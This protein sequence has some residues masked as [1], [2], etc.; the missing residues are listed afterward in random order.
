MICENP[1]RI[2]NPYTGQWLYTQ[3]RKCDGCVALQ[4]VSKTM[5]LTN[6][7]N[8]FKNVTFVTL[9]YDNKHLPI[10]LPYTSG[11][12]RYD[13][14]NFPEKLE[15][16]EEFFDFECE[17]PS[18]MDINCT[19]VLYYRDIQLF[20]KRF[21][22]YI[23]KNYGRKY[24]N[25][26]FFCLSEY[27]SERHRPHYH[28][29]FLSDSLTI[30]EVKDGC[31]HNWQ[32]CDWSKLNVDES[33][34]FGT[35]GVASY[36]AAYVNSLSNSCR[37]SSFKRFKQKTSRSKDISFGFDSE[38]EE[39]VKRFVLRKYNQ[40]SNF[41]NSEFF[42]DRQ[43]GVS[44]LSPEC[45]SP[46]FLYALFRKP[47]GFCGLS[48]NSQFR[49]ILEII[50]FYQT[51]SKITS[52]KFVSSSSDY[53]CWLGYRRFCKLFDVDVYSYNAPIFYTQSHL[54]AWSYYSSQALKFYLLSIQSLTPIEKEFEMYNTD[55]DNLEKREYRRLMRLPD[56]D[57][58][59]I[60]LFERNVLPSSLRHKCRKFIMDNKTKLL[61][62]HLNLYHF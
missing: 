39:E 44:S 9:T 12:Y 49:R 62:K 41:T 25:F 18:G 53:L 14:E 27:G 16:T 10:I 15:D 2:R 3:C 5:N 58:D 35:N 56:Y 13:G 36:L 61:P 28:L 51:R 1:Q 54:D 19:G 50:R 11:V 4:A 30:D 8:R 37:V 33:F 59:T 26:R 48:F 55:C 46:K 38:M 45:I 23:N 20:L 60:R 52:V 6:Y 40:G 17:K 57:L 42:I 32:L 24:N 43:K 29:L 21:R 47:K 7:I 34:K 31:L 22:K